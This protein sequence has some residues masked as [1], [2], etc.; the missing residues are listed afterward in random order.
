MNQWRS[1]RTVFGS[2]KV[3][4]HP[5]HASPSYARIVSLASLKKKFWLLRNIIYPCVRVARPARVLTV[6]WLNQR[7][8]SFRKDR[9]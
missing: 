6:H 9:I 5:T 8:A 4:A 7:R 2:N 3:Q 1:V